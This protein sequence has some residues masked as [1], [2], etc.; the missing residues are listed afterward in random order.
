MRDYVMSRVLPIWNIQ[1]K[2]GGKSNRQQEDKLWE[3]TVKPWSGAKL[4]GMFGR[5]S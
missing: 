1:S 5:K 4:Y 3:G 2:V